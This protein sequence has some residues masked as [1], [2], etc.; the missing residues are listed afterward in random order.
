[1]RFGI[2]NAEEYATLSTLVLTFTGFINLFFLCVPF[3]WIRVGCVSLSLICLIVAIA[4]MGDFFGITVLSAKVFIFLAFFLVV[5]IPLHIFI[6]KIVN[7]IDEKRMQRLKQT[8]EKGKVK[9]RQKAIHTD[10]KIN[11]KTKDTKAE[12]VSK[13]KKSAIDK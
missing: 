9:E 7:K 12:K 10:I 6:P 3:S 5:S 13:K 1:M 11:T 2:L 4:V 8:Q